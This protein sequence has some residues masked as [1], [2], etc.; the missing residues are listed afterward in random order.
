VRGDQ[1]P[2]E[3]PAEITV[4]QGLQQPGIETHNNCS[5][6]IRRG[7][8]GGIQRSPAAIASEV[9]EGQS[10]VRLLPPTV[11]DHGPE[12]QEAEREFAREGQGRLAEPALL[13]EAGNYQ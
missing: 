10:D 6:P 1:D 3:L 5:P 8:P 11:R 7:S 4:V 13:H 12:C 2:A 9:E